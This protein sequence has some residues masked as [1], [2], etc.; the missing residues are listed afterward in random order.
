M[1]KWCEDLIEYLY[2]QV[3]YSHR[4]SRKCHFCGE[5]L[6]ILPDN[7]HIIRDNKTEISFCSTRC[8]ISW[9]TSYNRDR[10]SFDEYRRNRAK[11]DE[12]FQ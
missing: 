4:R 6:A 3:C 9:I 12:W 10:R 8:S 5:F 2:T 7:Y 11:S 1:W